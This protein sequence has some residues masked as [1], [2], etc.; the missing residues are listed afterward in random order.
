MCTHMME[1]LLIN[2]IIN[3]TKREKIIIYIDSYS[4][5][6]HMELDHRHG[7]LLPKSIQ[8]LAACHLEMYF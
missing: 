5:C 3:E 6:Y 8:D 1:Y 4:K 7:G 2:W